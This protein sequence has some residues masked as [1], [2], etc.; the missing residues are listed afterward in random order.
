MRNW[1][2]YVQKD[3][4]LI[5]LSGHSGVGKDAV[6]E[7]LERI[8]P[9]VHRCVTTTT[10]PMRDYEVD[11]VDYTFIDVPEFRRRAEQNGF[12]EYAEVYGNLYGTP[13]EW[14]EENL[15]KGTD[16]VLK[17]DVQGGLSVKQAMPSAIMIFLVPPSMEELE[18]RLRTRNTETEESIARRLLTVRNEMDQIKNY[19][20]IIENDCLEKAAEDLKAVII[21]EHC[22]IRK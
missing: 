13:R 4:L 19:D 10:R 9:R 16:I 14:V 12:L 1:D 20:Y 22:K 11:G 5:V 6:L 21:A 8:Y 15:K 3:G 17:I 7:E 18:R 2:K